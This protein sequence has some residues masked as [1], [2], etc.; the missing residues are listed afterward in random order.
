MILKIKLFKN[1]FIAIML[2]L[3]FSQLLLAYKL[4]FFIFSISVVRNNLRSFAASLVFPLFLSSAASI[5]TISM[6]LSKA[7]RSTELFVSNHFAKSSGFG[8][9]VF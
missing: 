5:N 3:D 7:R 6:S 8:G 4:Y 2:F 9:L 1:F